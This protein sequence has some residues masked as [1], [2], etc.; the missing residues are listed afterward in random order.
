MLVSASVSGLILCSPRVAQADPSVSFESHAK[1]LVTLNNQLDAAL[2]YT[3]KIK[4]D[5]L[6]S[7]TG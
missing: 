7:I 3:F 6:Y 2:V 1:I 5:C 4:P